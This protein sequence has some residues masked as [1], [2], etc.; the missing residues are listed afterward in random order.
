MSVR[1][2]Q[3]EPFF[4]YM[5]ILLLFTVTFA[6]GAKAAVDHTNL[7]ALRPV[8][9]FHGVCMMCW[10]LLFVIQAGGIQYNRFGMHQALGLASLA[11]APLM[12][13]SGIWVTIGS[14]EVGGDTLLFLGNLV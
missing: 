14:Y 4:F 13:I 12:V 6:F 1:K 3:G 9:I 2:P 10:Y 5:G 8:I 7:L 11:I